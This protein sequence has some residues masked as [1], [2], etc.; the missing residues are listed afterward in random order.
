MS[1]EP[2]VSHNWWPLMKL[3]HS[4]IANRHRNRSN[5][6]V[7]HIVTATEC[8]MLGMFIFSRWACQDKAKD[9][10]MFPNLAKNQ[11]NQTFP[12]AFHGPFPFF[13]LNGEVVSFL[14]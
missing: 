3:N 10:R 4:V 2:E 11:S 7:Y 14:R 6:E 1:Q 8:L 12:F 13:K 5:N 9:C